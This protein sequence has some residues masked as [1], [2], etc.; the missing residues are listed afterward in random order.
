MTNKANS[1]QTL[2]RAELLDV[3]FDFSCE[4]LAHLEDVAFCLVFVA[5]GAQEDSIGVQDAQVVLQHPHVVL[6]A[7]EAMLEHEQM[8][9]DVVIDPFKTL[10]LSLC[11]DLL[12]AHLVRSFDLLH[13]PEIIVFHIA[14]FEDDRSYFVLVGHLS[15]S[16]MLLFC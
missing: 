6:V 15:L 10:Q 14:L 9:T 16:Q 7:L 1:C 3:A 12:L 4:A 2:H 11:G 5:G 8:N 13:K